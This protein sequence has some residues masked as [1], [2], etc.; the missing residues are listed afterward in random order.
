MLKIGHTVYMFGT[1]APVRCCI[2]LFQRRGR[3]ECHRGGTPCWCTC[4]CG[5][6]LY[7]PAPSVASILCP[8]AHLHAPRPALDPRK[9]QFSERW[10]EAAHARDT[11]MRTNTTHEGAVRTEAIGCFYGCLWCECAGGPGPQ[12]A[13]T[14]VV[15]ALSPLGCARA[16]AAA[17]IGQGR[18]TTQWT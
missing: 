6:L 13:G 12:M 7:V 17:H 16:P 11:P 8:R 9:L 1:T 3:P 18:I 2:R 5:V 15:C 10:G 4:G 14:G